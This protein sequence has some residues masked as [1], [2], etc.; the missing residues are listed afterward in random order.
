MA[1][2]VL[3]AGLMPLQ[4]QAE[5]TTRVQPLAEIRRT[6][7][8]I[9]HIKARDWRG[10][11]HGLGFVQAQDALCTLA[12]GFVTFE[13][14]RSLY[15]GADERPAHNATFGRAKNL[16]LDLFF[17][18]FATP[19]VLAEY[20]RHQPAGLNELIDGFAQG[21]NRFLADARAG[22]VARQDR[23]ACLDQPWVRPITSEDIFRRMVAA[24]LAAGYARFVPEIVNAA[25]PE[26][27]AASAPGATDADRL[28][29]DALRTR[30]ANR[31]GDLAGLG[32]NMIAIG[33]RGTGEAGG[34][35]FGNPHWFW[36][37]P[38]RFYQAHLTIPGQVDVA[39]VS[40]LGI[41]VIMIGFNQHVAWSHT[42]SAARRF[43]LFE[44]ALAPAAP[45]RYRVDG[46]AEPMQATTVS[47]EVRGEGGGA[48]RTV[49]RTLYRTRLGPL[50]D[51]GGYDPAFGWGTQQ[52]LAIR[53]VN[54]ANYRIFST[55]FQWNQ[56]RSLDEFVAI[57]KREASMPW[58]NTAAIGRGDGRVW[59]ADIGAVPNTPDALRKACATPLSQ[60]FA[61]FDPITPFLDGSRSACEWQVDAAAAQP[62][63]MP[64]RDQPGIFRDDYVANMNDSHWLANPSA[65][66]EGYASVLGGERQALSLRGRQGHR[67]A[68]AMVERAAP[69]AAAMSRRLMAEVLGARAHS[70]DLFKDELLAQACRQPRVALPAAPAASA[71]G[72]PPQAMAPRVVD[73]GEACQVLRRWPNTARAS[74]RGSVLWDAFWLGV[75]RIPE[76]ALYAVPFSAEQPL[77]TPRAPR[78]DPRVAQALAAAVVTMADKGWPLDAPRG[79]LLFARSEGRP[80]PMY[81]GCHFAGYFTVACTEG[82]GYELGP[83]SEGNSYLQMVSFGR[84]GVEAFTLLAHGERETAVANGAGGSAVR[85]YAR[86]DWLRLPFQEHEIQRD[87]ALALTVLYP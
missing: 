82:G 54:E 76:A 55:F 36:G 58:V 33:Q 56:A 41:P 5:T 72:A 62:G 60:A 61:G 75:A 26:A 64:A 86:Q 79:S 20:R 4:G 35:L 66:L 84:K 22:R 46:V 23:P 81:G 29:A 9:P 39:G 30:L 57:Q 24:N 50:V 14:R 73:V 17:K 38:D 25:Q 10:L 3:L 67:I 7:D 2:L 71:S 59:Y 48:P 80:V 1:G 27:P 42:V 77:S 45:T 11:G 6:T 83:S 74:D 13:G 53:D 44:L 37:G 87:R 78:A 85:R 15:F 28:G 52:A 19:Q 68:G 12:D 51:L 40:F 70:A 43:G 31:V 34:V 47:V 63:A 65:P 32:S 69:S 16:E 49:S 18:A 21:Y 8:G